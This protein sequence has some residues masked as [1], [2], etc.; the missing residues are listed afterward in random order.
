MRKI[1]ILCMVLSLFVLSGCRS[2][3]TQ[4]NI[5][6][7]ETYMISDFKYVSKDNVENTSI[8]KIEDTLKNETIKSNVLI[9]NTSY[10]K[11]FIFEQETSID[12]AGFI[13]YETDLYYYALTNYHK[14]KLISGYEQQRFIVTDAYGNKYDAFMYEGSKDVTFDLA[15]MVFSKKEAVLP[16]LPIV[17]GKLSK[18]ARVVSIS[19][20]VDEFGDISQGTI[21]DYYGYQ[22]DQEV[23]IPWMDYYTIYAHTCFVDKDSRGGFLLD[24]DLAVVGI[25]FAADKQQFDINEYV[26]PSEYIVDYLNRVL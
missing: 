19:N 21:K 8:F 16:V 2:K 25:S 11:Q 22:P 14:V 18:T 26:L 5:P 17:Y 12:G 3:D 15:V 4:E 1:L 23:F 9:K 10:K 7:Y 24:Y 6:E 13:F 20:P